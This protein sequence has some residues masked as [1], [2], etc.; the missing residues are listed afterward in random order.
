MK[1]TQIHMMTFIVFVVYI[2]QRVYMYGSNGLVNIA[3]IGML[4]MKQ[5]EYGGQIN[6]T[7]IVRV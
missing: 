7:I 5:A 1:E 6:A 4:V 2:I 3:S